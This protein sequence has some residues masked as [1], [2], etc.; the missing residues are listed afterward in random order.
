MEWVTTIVQV[1]LVMIVVMFLYAWGYVKQQRQSQELILQLEKKGKKKIIKA[2]K[3]RKSMSKK[4]IEQELTDLKAS[5]FYSKNKAFVK[6]SKFIAE[7][8]IKQLIESD[9]IYIDN[10]GG[11]EKYILK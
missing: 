4:E 9:I 5:L 2:L 8:I 7:R 6:D 10:K 1:L 3:K 11:N